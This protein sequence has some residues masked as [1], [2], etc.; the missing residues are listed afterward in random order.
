MTSHTFKSKRSNLK[1]VINQEARLLQKI[2]EHTGKA[3]SQT[4]QIKKG[5]KTSK[6]VATKLKQAND[7]NSG[8]QIYHMRR[9]PDSTILKLLMQKYYRAYLRWIQKKVSLFLFD[10]EMQCNYQNSL[11]H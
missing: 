7:Y 11:L 5:G 3:L 8:I 4:F 2:A 1:V 6:A 9:S 10:Y